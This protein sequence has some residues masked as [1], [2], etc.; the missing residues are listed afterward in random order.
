MILILVVAFFLLGCSFS[1]NGMK[2]YFTISSGCSAVLT[3]DNLCALY[4]EKSFPDEG[5][6]PSQGGFIQDFKSKYSA[7]A[8]DDINGKIRALWSQ[9]AVC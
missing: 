9:R 8:N 3:D 2:E 6:F 1:C 4:K 7:C 5:S